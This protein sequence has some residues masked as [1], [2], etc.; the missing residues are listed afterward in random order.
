MKILT[1][2]YLLINS[3]TDIKYRLIDMRCTIVYFGITSLILIYQKESFLGMGCLPGAFL[4]FLSFITKRHIGVGDGVMVLVIGCIVGLEEI[5]YI[6]QLGFII[7]AIWG[8]LLVLKRVRK[9]YSIPFAPCLLVGY[10]ISLL[11]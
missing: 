2:I 8:I 3:W 11:E 5:L 6:L 1:L 7:A 4:C 9:G 10:L